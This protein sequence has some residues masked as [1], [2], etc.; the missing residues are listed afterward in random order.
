MGQ[1]ITVEQSERFQMRARSVLLE[2]RNL[3]ERILYRDYIKA[4]L[5]MGYSRDEANRTLDA[6]PCSLQSDLTITFDEPL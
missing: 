6:L 2:L 4:M 5:G 1:I 3:D